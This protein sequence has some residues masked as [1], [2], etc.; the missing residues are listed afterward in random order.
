MHSAQGQLARVYSE[1]LT[2]LSYNGTRVAQCVMVAFLSILLILAGD[3]EV[4][5]GP[6]KGKEKAASG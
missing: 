3:V 4:N 5:P 6:G 1:M 2:C